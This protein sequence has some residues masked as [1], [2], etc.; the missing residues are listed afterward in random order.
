[1][2]DPASSTRQTCLSPNRF[3][4]YEPAAH[5]MRG[6]S[7]RVGLARSSGE[8]QLL[9]W[10]ELAPSGYPDVDDA[11][12]DTPAVGVIGAS[13]ARALEPIP[14]PED[15][16]AR[17]PGAAWPLRSHS[18]DLVRARGMDGSREC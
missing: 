15:G 6:D 17:L 7:G 5:P 14:L 2:S 3:E 8:Q 11:G 18:I 1:M 4:H 12:A 13:L 10:G 9:W 16:A